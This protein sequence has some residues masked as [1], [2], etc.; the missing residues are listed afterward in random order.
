M[1]YIYSVEGNIGSGK[2]TLVRHLK[3]NL[4]QIYYENPFS[5]GDMGSTQDIIKKKISFIFL[6]Q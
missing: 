5:K 2:S 1:V 3:D 4:K 6:N